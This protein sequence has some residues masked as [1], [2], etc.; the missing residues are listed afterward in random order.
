MIG[1]TVYKELVGIALGSGSTMLVVG[2]AVA[3]PT[4]LKKIKNK[5]LFFPT[6]WLLVVRHGSPIKKKKKKILFFLLRALWPPNLL[7]KQNLFL[8]SSLSHASSLSSLPFSSLSLSPSV[9]PKLPSLQLQAIII[10]K[11]R[12]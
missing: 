1:I 9:P 7:N 8:F 3:A 10:D 5:K 12:L 2:D 11:L 6:L 4:T